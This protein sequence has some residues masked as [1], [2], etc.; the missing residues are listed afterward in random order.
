MHI[1]QFCP[2]QTLLVVIMPLHTYVS[3]ITLYMAQ[4]VCLIP[5]ARSASEEGTTREAGNAQVGGRCGRSWS[6][7]T[8]EG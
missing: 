5:P 6:K 3:F 1:R 4:I 7:A 2:K 8:S